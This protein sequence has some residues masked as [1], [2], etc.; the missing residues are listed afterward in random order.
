MN[1]IRPDAFIN[2]LQGKILLTGNPLPKVIW[3]QIKIFVLSNKDGKSQL[4]LIMK[5]NSFF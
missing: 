5:P 4:S 1:Q 3:N 2:I